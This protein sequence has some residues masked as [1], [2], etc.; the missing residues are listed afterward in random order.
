MKLAV[1][2]ITARNFFRSNF[3]SAF[4]QT[5]EQH[6]AQS[7]DPIRTLHSQQHSLKQPNRLPV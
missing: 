5:T 2:K 7:N 4:T 3:N 1:R 6:I